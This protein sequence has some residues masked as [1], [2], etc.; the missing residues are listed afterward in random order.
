MRKINPY[1]LIAIGV[2]VLYVPFLGSTP[3]FD[4]DEIN[5]AESAR[6]MIVTGEY[7]KVMVNYDAF[8]EKPPMFFWLQVVSMKIF[9]VNEFASRF[10]NVLTGLATLLIIF[11]IGRKVKDEKFAWFW[12][13][14]MT[15]SLTPHLYFHSGIIDPLFNL[16]I[17]LSVFQLFRT[18]ENAD[19]KPWLYA[20]IFTG[21]AILTKGPVAVLISAIVFVTIV[22]RKGFWFR[23]I[24]FLLWPLLALF[25]TSVWFLPEVF[26]NGWGFLLN[27]IR[28]Q[29]DLFSQPVASHGQPWFYHF[30]VLLFGAIPAS[31]LMLPALFRVESGEDKFSQFTVWMKVLF[32]TVLILFSIVTTKIV[33]YS[34]MC[35][36]PM[37]FL[38]AITLHEISVKK[39]IVLFTGVI[40]FLVFIGLVIL[41]YIGLHNLELLKKYG[42]L[43]KDEFT[44]A[45]L[46]VDGNWSLWDFIPAVLMMV[47]LLVLLF[48]LLKKKYWL[49]PA[50]LILSFAN[51][52]SVWMLAPNVERHTQHSVIEFLKE[53]EGEDCYVEPFRY[54]S[55]ASYFY[56][57]VKPLKATDSLYIKKREWLNSFNANELTDLMEEDR[58]VYHQKLNEWLLH[59][60]IDKPVY[61]ICLEKKISLLE[62]EPEL[63]MVMHRGGYAAFRREKK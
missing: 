54:K 8:W 58:N 3:L 35:Y 60:E 61:L 52:T 49:I 51:T 21:L 31:V 38:A 26:R 18:V 6:E 2:M 29:L 45:N 46:A 9:G 48:A 41:P 50:F 30:V 11:W 56:A 37:T 16:F 13:L 4:W 17:F 15:A 43:I 40:L 14:L 55:Y 22:I 33:H 1:V 34:S 20:G 25:I 59:G 36:L 53:I 42:D 32:L 44:K 7:S 24:H 23:W 19:Y 12:V 27:F 39:S 57:K 5:F 47:G 28:Y 10:P 62:T 63:K